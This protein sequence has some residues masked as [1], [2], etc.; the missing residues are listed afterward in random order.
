MLDSD[1]VAVR[2]MIDDV[3]GPA[4]EDSVDIRLG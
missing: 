1:R 4:A 2:A 3:F